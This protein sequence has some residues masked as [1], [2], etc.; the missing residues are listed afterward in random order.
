[1][2]NDEE[3]ECKSRLDKHLHDCLCNDEDLECDNIP[4]CIL[5]G[6]DVF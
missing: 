4:V 2:S 1:M 3:S 6:D 5:C